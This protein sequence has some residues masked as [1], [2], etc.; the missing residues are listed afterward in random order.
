[1]C[2][3]LYGILLPPPKSC[4]APARRLRPLKLHEL[5]AARCQ[6]PRE[7]WPREPSRWHS[8][9]Q[10]AVETLRQ[11]QQRQNLKALYP[12]IM[13]VW[14]PMGTCAN[15]RG[16][17]SEAPRSEACGAASRSHAA[18]AIATEL[19]R[20]PHKTTL[21]ASVSMS[22]PPPPYIHSTDL[23]PV[24]HRTQPLPAPNHSALLHLLRVQNTG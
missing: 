1:M 8:L 24:L 11:G 18:L 3:Y 23:L 22:V 6:R 4:A 19:V 21:T 12:S 7:G 9:E 17:R 15:T 5:P 16:G 13:N 20:D 14:G 10:P 2:V